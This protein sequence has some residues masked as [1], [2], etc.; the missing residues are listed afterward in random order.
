MSDRTT[1]PSQEEIAR[2][3]YEIY[4]CRGQKNGGDIDDWLA[5]EQQ[6]REHQSSTSQTRKPLLVT[7]T[8]TERKLPLPQ[9][10]FQ[11]ALRENAA[12]DNTIRENVTREN[13]LREN[14][15]LETSVPQATQRDGETHFKLPRH[16]SGSN[17][18]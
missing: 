1:R 6:L 9:Q 11:A 14:A 8:L 15:A 5:A 10:N 4:V 7:G 13:A 12:R 17:P 18:K 16:F 2:R 3:A